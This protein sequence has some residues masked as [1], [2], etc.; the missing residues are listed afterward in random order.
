MSPSCSRF[1]GGRPMPE[2]VD[3]SLTT[4]DGQRLRQH[5]E[6]LALPFREKM[7][8]LE[9]LARTADRL[10]GE[11]AAAPSTDDAPRSLT[12]QPPHSLRGPD[13]ER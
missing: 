5:R 10:R 4:W 1:T 2:P 6:F 13:P 3:W 8:Q 9:E 11:T 12:P 7:Q